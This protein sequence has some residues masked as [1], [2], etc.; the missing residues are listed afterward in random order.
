[1]TKL[2]TLDEAK[3]HLRVDDDAQDDEI[4]SK[5]E[6][7]SAIII[8][9]LKA[10]T[11]TVETWLDSAGEP[12]SVPGVV[13]SAT[14]LALGELYKNREAEADPLTPSVRGLLH[15]LRDPALA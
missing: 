8:D 15:R 3:K 10:T 9:Y 1:M 5:I 14:L 4:N 11:A 12:T 13:K 7:A 6:M 2:I